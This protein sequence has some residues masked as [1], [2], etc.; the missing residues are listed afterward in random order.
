MALRKMWACTMNDFTKEELKELILFV[1]GGIRHAT[2][3]VELRN[4]LQSMI[5]NYCDHIWIFHLKLP[6]SSI[7][8]RKCQKV[9]QNIT[10]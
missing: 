10:R 6:G 7:E 4:K 5:D 9:L 2:H 8:C 3:A 1:D